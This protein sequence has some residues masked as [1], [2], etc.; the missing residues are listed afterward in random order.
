MSNSLPVK[1]NLL[2]AVRVLSFAAMAVCLGLFYM[3][4]SGRITSLAGCGGEGGCGQVM[5]GEWSEWFNIPVTLAAA[6]VYVGVLLLTLPPVQRV[7]GK[8]GDQLLAAAGVILAGAAVYFLCLLYLKERAHCPWCLSLH[9]TGL[10]VS[11]LIL[12]M[13]VKAQREGER[14]VL[15]AAM[16][17]GFM[18]IGLLAAGQ[19][20]GPKPDTHVLTKGGFTPSSVASGLRE[21]PGSAMDKALPPRVIGFFNGELNFDVL[22][23]PLLGPRDARVVL[24]EFFDYTCG[25]CRDLAGDLKELKKK[26]PGTFAVIALPSPLNRACNPWLKDSVKNH[27][28]ACE[29]ARI[30]LACWRAKPS[31]FEA[32]HEFLMALPLPAD[33]ARI[34]VARKKADELAGAPEMQAAMED[35]WVGDRLQQNL[36]TFAKLTSQNIVMPKLLLHTSVMMHGPA[37]DTETFIRVMEQQFDV[38]GSGSPV[39]HGPK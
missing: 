14:G 28:G 19:V 37:K 36:G 39:I 16:L 8:T 1:P 21:V 23:L 30:S 10:V 25:S 38:A 7:L 12:S 3:K 32:L 5:G 2:W 17:T 9:V 31:A 33:E 11:G 35:V 20:W 34:A 24:V 4:V 26:W 29:L 22:S 15:E 6:G 13:S 18:A 27:P